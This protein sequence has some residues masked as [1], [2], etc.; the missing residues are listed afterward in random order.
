MKTT[1]SQRNQNTKEISDFVVSRLLAV[2]PNWMPHALSAHQVHMQVE[3][4]LPAMRAG[5]DDQ[6]VTGLRDALL[7][8]ELFGD[9]EKP[10]HH[11]LIFGQD[12]IDRDNVFDRHDQQVGGRDRMDI[13]KSDDLLVL[14]KDGSRC[15]PFDDLAENAVIHVASLGLGLANYKGLLE[16]ATF[17]IEMR[18]LRSSQ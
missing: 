2:L 9:R 11:G 8:G 13:A 16:T 10:P 5:V 1:K 17:Y 14:V 7:R 6:A 4:N 3:D 18:L 12:V 15:F